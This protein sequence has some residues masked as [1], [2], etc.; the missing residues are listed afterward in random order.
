MIRRVYLS[1]KLISLK[2]INR[3]K[4]TCGILLKIK[5]SVV[6]SMNKAFKLN[7]QVLKVGSYIIN[8]MFLAICNKSFISLLNT[9]FIAIVLFFINDLV[10]FNEVKLHC[11]LLL[12]NLNYNDSFFF[13]LIN[14]LQ[15][16]ELIVFI[17]ALTVISFSSAASTNA[18]KKN[19]IVY[20]F[21]LYYQA[22]RACN[23]SFLFLKSKQ[24]SLF[25]LIKLR[26]SRS[27]VLNI[28]RRFK[29]TQLINER[30]LKFN[31][32]NKKKNY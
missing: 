17:L 19:S 21:F 28:L 8:F 2:L 27:L 30:R 3:I 22:L 20:L 7:K 32:R 25:L 4:K 5:A 16:S 26:A 23:A 12:S 6:I 29:L 18:H 10:I 15:P 31:L 14:L 9:I 24:V 1:V 13:N 11:A